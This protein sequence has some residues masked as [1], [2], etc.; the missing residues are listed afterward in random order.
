VKQATLKTGDRVLLHEGD[1]FSGQLIVNWSGTAA[2]PAVVGAYYLENGAARQGFQTARPII[3]G[4]AKAIDQYDAQIRIAGNYVR[5][6]NLAVVSSAGRGVGAVGTSYVEIVQCTTD[7]TYKNGII[8]VDSSHPTIRGNYVS[9]AI[10][11]YPATGNAGG[12]GIELVRTT[13]GVVARNTLSLVY[14]EGINANEGSARTLIEDN[15]VYGVRSAGIYI[16]AAPYVTVRRNVVIGTANSEF[17][18]DDNGVG[19]GIALNNEVYHYEDRGLAASVQTQHARVYDNLV[20]GTN[21]GIG[22]WGAFAGSSFDDVLIFNNTLVDN[23][24]Q[25][26]MTSVPKPG[27][28]FV[29][30]ILLSMTPGTLDVGGTRLGGMVAH[31][32]YFSRGNPG[33]DFDAAGNKYSGLAL[34]RMTNWRTALSMS[35]ATTA[36][37]WRDFMQL[38]SSTAIGAGADDPRALADG[39]DTFDRDYTNALHNSPMDLGAL[40]YAPLPGA[41]PKA[42]RSLALAE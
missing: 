22:V 24:I 37:S 8:F 35:Q 26:S 10:G 3:D 30:N 5:V 2:A 1:R 20:A 15:F 7:K 41:K 11:S 14:G 23:D 27:A 36:L 40:R 16:D 4:Q 38:K 39:D 25:A 32:N 13:D 9:L 42:P 6:E 31:H 29:N 33:G 12:G 21:A 19:A 34:A 17:W 18:R 28:K